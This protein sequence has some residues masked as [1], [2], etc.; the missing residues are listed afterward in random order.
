MLESNE[1]EDLSKDVADGP[2]DFDGDVEAKSDSSSF[3]FCPEAPPIINL[4]R[5]LSMRISLLEKNVKK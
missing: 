5:D 2:L 4:W 3:R 1:D